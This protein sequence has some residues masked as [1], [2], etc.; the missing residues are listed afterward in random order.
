MH[1]SCSAHAQLSW[2]P[3]SYHL[4][5]RFQSSLAIAPCPLE[6]RSN[7]YT[8]EMVQDLLGEGKYLGSICGEPGEGKAGWTQSW[9]V[10]S[11]QRGPQS[12]SL[13]KSEGWFLSFGEVVANPVAGG[14]Y[15]RIR[16]WTD[17][18]GPL[19]TLPSKKLGH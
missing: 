2:G 13:R 3:K 4:P 9:L 16:A 14:P 1:Q 19:S 17:Q 18:C 8:T 12:N 7:P 10:V 11:V 15:T 6:I 5:G